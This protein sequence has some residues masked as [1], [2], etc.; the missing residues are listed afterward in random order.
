MFALGLGLVVLG[1][2]H[3][4]MALGADAPPPWDGGSSLPPGIDPASTWAIART[5]ARSGNLG[6]AEAELRRTLSHRPDDY[7]LLILLGNVLL[8]SERPGEA[9]AAFL[10]ALDVAPG[11]V[12]ALEG[13]LRALGSAERHG[14]ARAVLQELAALCSPGYASALALAFHTRRGA[15]WLAHAAAVDHVRTHGPDPAARAILDAPLGIDS[16]LEGRLEARPFGGY[17]AFGARLRLVPHQRVKPELEFDRSSWIGTT[18]T[19]FGGGLFVQPGG[20]LSLRIGVAG[21]APG[22]RI[23]GF[24]LDAGAGLRFLRRVDV[25]AGW[26]WRVYTTGVRSHLFRLGG[27]LGPRDQPLVRS[28]AFLGVIHLPGVAEPQLAPGVSVAVVL[29]AHKRLGFEI[30]G[31]AG[32]DLLQR[33]GATARLVGTF[34]WSALAEWRLEERLTFLVEGGI[35]GWHDRAPW[36]TLLARS[37]VHW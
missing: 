29:P 14:E 10:A 27:S 36:P 21:G 22:I 26:T 5:L 3:S 8:W 24:E 12:E 28:Y 11:S 18:E 23:P 35:E 13:R 32:S 15:R 9:D 16:I 17:G 37:T 19:R 1:L 31:A 30:R 7:D 34:R 20:G 33:P 6:G 2:A 25:E 4:P